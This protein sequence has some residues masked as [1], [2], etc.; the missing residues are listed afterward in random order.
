[1][2]SF[3]VAVFRDRT[4]I[5]GYRLFNLTDFGLSVTVRDVTVEELANLL[6]I[7]PSASL[8]NGN[9]NADGTIEFTQGAASAYPTLSDS[10]TL[11]SVA[12]LTIVYAVTDENDVVLGYGVVDS[13]G[14]LGNV[15]KKKLIELSNRFKP[16]NWEVYAR[17]GKSD[18][19][20]KS[21]TFIRVQKYVAPSIKAI[22][23][24]SDSQQEIEEKRRINAKVLQEIK[25]AN[26]SEEELIKKLGKDIADEIVS[27]ITAAKNKGALPTGHI[28]SELIS[29]N[30]NKVLPCLKVHDFADTVGTS[31][32]IDAQKKLVLIKKN[33][34]DVAP[35]YATIFE[36]V[37]KK[38]TTAIPTWAVSEDTFFFN[39]DFT[40]QQSIPEGTFWLIHEMLHIAMQ[41]SVRHGKRDN[42]L[43][44]IACDLYINSI[45]CRD[46][47]CKFGG[48][49]TTVTRKS[50]FNDKVYTGSIKAPNWGMF[51]ETFG[52]EIDFA[53]DT[54]ESIYAR[55]LKEN[56]NIQQQLQNN[57]NNGKPQNGQG[58]QSGS[59]GGQQGGQGGQQSGNSGQGQSQTGG[60]Q[61]GSQSGQG[62]SQSGQ[63]GSQSGQGSQ[64]GTQGV[65]QGGSQGSQGS[66]SI[67][68][69]SNDF[70]NI[71]N[72][73]SADAGEST[74][75][76]DLQNADNAEYGQKEVEV[77]VT[78]NG[79]TKRVKVP[80]DVV[81]NQDSVGKEAQS[82]SLT[83]TK[84]VL[85]RIRIKKDMAIKQGKDIG[86]SSGTVMIDREIEFALTVLYNWEQILRNLANEKPK[87][88]YTLAKPNRNYMQ[89]GAT[90][91][92]RQ[93]HGKPT[94]ISGIKFGVD[95]SGSR[96]SK[97]M[98]QMFTK[99]SDILNQ[100]EVSAEMI[101]WDTQ[102]TN[103]GDFEDLRGLM[104]IQPTGCGGTDVRCLFDYLLGRTK[105]GNGR[106]E[107][108]PLKDITGVL[109]FTDGY[110]SDNYGEYA[111]Y[112]G[113][114]TYWVVD[115]ESPAFKPLFGKVIKAKLK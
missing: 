73:A 87:K 52:I 54:A 96:G 49:I 70:D 4:K 86:M 1:M 58:N 80:L 81:S 77:D 97:E 39:P 57:S 107:Q 109:I 69:T 50:G 76:D 115:E 31:A 28:S 88:I 56:P 2:A 10:G 23:S 89:M 15:S 18:I 33:L 79:V 53:R 37:D 90:L 102:V 66:D 44:N 17:N 110:I 16:T 114:T 43:W 101:Y 61:G 72:D 36:A 67:G 30:S 95:V 51:M 82:K 42:V 13:Y 112:F 38:Q 7:R 35:Y 32:A 60:Q 27:D 85:R 20:A 94:K 24:Y 113:R 22:N 3:A 71:G 41:H 11:L 34:L 62:G 26:K 6:R 55:L 99:I 25:E 9:I 106:T 78:F 105:S 65:G 46:F 8:I 84:T 93:R 108:T 45:I 64:S 98:A 47:G 111:K 48:G 83:D 5:H 12:G 63:G 100:F 104:R 21:G 14:V 19:R 103:V 40:A 91:A 74:L 29:M 68:N 59:Q 75:K 92:S